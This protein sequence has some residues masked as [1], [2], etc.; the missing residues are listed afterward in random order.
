MNKTVIAFAALL[1]LAA[2]GY[3][4]KCQAQKEK[5][6]L[7]LTTYHPVG[8][9]GSLV[10]EV[11]KTNFIIKDKKI[12]YVRIEYTDTPMQGRD[13]G[14]CYVNTDDLRLLAMAIEKI[15]TYTQTK[16]KDKTKIVCQTTAYCMLTSEFNGSKWKTLLYID[17]K[18]APMRIRKKQLWKLAELVAKTRKIAG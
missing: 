8:N 12:N 11:Q 2:L 3:A 10:V 15:Q 7:R 5:Q 13:K 1:I 17:P 18:V 6:A 4:P 14:D 9:I 16:P